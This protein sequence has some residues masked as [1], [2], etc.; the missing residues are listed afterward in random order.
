M[1][2]ESGALDPAGGENPLLTVSLVIYRPDLKVLAA[3]LQSLSNAMRRLDASRCKVFVIQNCDTDGIA[4]LLAAHLNGFA[5]DLRQGHGNI[6]FGRAHNLALSETGTFHL[7]LNPDIEMAEEALVNG[8][9]FLEEHTDCGLITPH[10]CWPDGTRQYLCK[11]YPA[12]F[13]LLLR[14]F[15]PAFLKNLF[16]D[17][18]ARYEMSEETGEDVF[19]DP[20]IVSG[21]FM[22]FRGETYRQLGG[23]DPRFF[24]YFED[25]DLALRAGKVTRTAYVPAVRIVHEGG[26]AARKGLTHIKLFAKSALLFYRLN[27]FK[28]F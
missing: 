6:G 27:G 13:D 20:P 11:R 9:K 23:F 7:V 19:W 3:T 8:L 22:L 25:F 17:R 10:A 4:L 26:H 2:G 18:L 16:S 21:C 5:F 1:T 28:L 15:A 12:L 24:L 14:G